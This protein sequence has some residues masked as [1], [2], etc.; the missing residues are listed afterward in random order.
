MAFFKFRQRGQAPQP[1]PT[2]RRSRKDEAS[3][4]AQES[5][6]T[7][8]RRARHR[9]LGAVV[10]VGVAVIGF[11]LLF[12]TQPRPIAVN[13]PIIIPDKDAAGPLRTPDAGAA[14][15]SVPADASLGE[16]EEMVVPGAR[17]A[18]APV[19][20]PREAP[21]R[22]A[23]A[24]AL[25]APA[26]G[27]ES[28]ALRTSS[29]ADAKAKR[30]AEARARRE[31]DA[32]A[33]REAEAKAKRE[34]DAR[35]KREEDARARREQQA[36]ASEDSA[37]ESDRRAKAEQ[38]TKA[39]REAEA[40]RDAEAKRTADAQAKRQAEAKAKRDEEAKAKREEEAKA[41]R[42][43][44]AR[45]R[46]LLEGRSSSNADRKA[47]EPAAKSRYVIQVGAYADDAATRQARQKAEAAGVK[48]YT[49][50]VETS[51]GKRTR[52]RVGPFNSREEAEK[53]SAALKKAGLGAA[54]LGL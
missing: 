40:K 17:T 44:A 11:P 47:D 46:A 29:E 1:E 27:A 34:A 35:A 45:A 4:A 6:E 51:A 3:A 25:S 23:S 52:V 7:V 14:S 36:A 18:E 5:I 50:V 12:D 22:P 28:A 41:K 53:A 13:A 26:R 19:A 32:K 31:A 2:G 48:T 38:E 21:A 30:E 15:R 24:S 54:I 16:R 9:L 20:A 43:D 33:K 10:L 37:P 49:Q 42:D 8:R 39:K